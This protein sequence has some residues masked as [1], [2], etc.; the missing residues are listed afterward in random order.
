MQ[1]P[2]IAWSRALLVVDGTYGIGNGRTLPAGP[3]RQPWPEALAAADAIVLVGEDRTGILKLSE[4]KPLFRA[5]IGS[6]GD[7]SDLAGRRLLAFAGMPMSAEDWRARH[8]A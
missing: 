5:S 8:R 4:G 7:Y 2:G 1:H 3:L 6:A